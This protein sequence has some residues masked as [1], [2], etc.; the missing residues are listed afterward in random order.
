MKQKPIIQWWASTDEERYEPFSTREQAVDYIDGFTGWVGQGYQAEI[1]LAEHF[2][3][4]DWI[5]QLSEGALEEQLDPD[6]GDLGIP[7]QAI[8]N[9]EIQVRATIRKWQDNLT[10]ALTSWTITWTIHPEKIEADQYPPQPCRR[11]QPCD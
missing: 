5:C 4:S 9:L 3:A 10:T 1:D 8:H 6:D 2:D 11:K 7:A